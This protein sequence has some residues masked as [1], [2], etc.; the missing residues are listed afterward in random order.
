MAHNNTVYNQLLQII[1]RHQF[2]KLKNNYKLKR[3]YRKFDRWN[4]F[5]VMTFAQLTGCSG[6]RNLENQFKVHKNSKYHVGLRSVKKSTMADANNQRDPDFLRNCTISSTRVALSMF[7]GT[8]SS[9]KAN[10]FLLMLQQLA[11]IK[12]TSP[13]Q[14]S[15]RQK[16]L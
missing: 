7:Q 1:D 10:F 6:L 5:S 16:A 15:E 3:R 12:P 14:S 8:N 4:Q 9:S 2:N 13:V 11:L